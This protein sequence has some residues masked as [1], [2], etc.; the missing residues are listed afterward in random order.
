VAGSP[1]FGARVAKVTG[2]QETVEIT[3]AANTP[4]ELAAR[5]CHAFGEVDRR[6][7]ENNRRVLEAGDHAKRLRVSEVLAEQ[8]AA[9]DVEAETLLAERRAEANGDA[10]AG[11]ADAP[12]DS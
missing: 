4:V 1:I 2:E 11:T 5:L 9:G 3:V 8:A 7:I 12:T 10:P 6:M